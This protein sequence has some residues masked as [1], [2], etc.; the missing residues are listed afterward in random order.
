M[1][2]WYTN[3][4]SSQFPV[5]GKYLF[6][7]FFFVIRVLKKCMDRIMWCQWHKSYGNWAKNS[8]ELG[9]MSR[10]GPPDV[11]GILFDREIFS[12]LMAVPRNLWCPSMIENKLNL[13]ILKKITINII[14][15]REKQI[16][17][18]SIRGCGGVISLEFGGTSKGLWWTTN[19]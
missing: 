14:D 1:S 8:A 9:V 6:C 10:C 11:S 12:T 17:I 5:G 2:S 13:C 19:W 18:L 7:E 16:L 15:F 4:P 3:G